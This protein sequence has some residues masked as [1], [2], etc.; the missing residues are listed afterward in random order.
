M[1]DAHPAG[2]ADAASY[3]GELHRLTR[4]AAATRGDGGSLSLDAAIEWAIR[5]IVSRNE[6]GNK[7]MVIGNGGSA[8]IA[9]HI[10]TDYT[11]NGGL[12]TQVFNDGSLLTCLGNDLGFERVFAKP[13]EM[14]ARRGD[15]LIAISSSGK[16]PNIH[17]GVEAARAAGC[18]VLTLSGFGADNPLRRMG[19]VN[20]YVASGEY[21]FV[22]LA[23]M[24]LCH[25]ILDMKMGWRP[26]SGA[27][28]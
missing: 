2:V 18:A 3:F 19:D 11:K 5:E 27:R 8:A 17:R 25:A 26:P 6:A 24:G 28:S 4:G 23:H 22:E 10:A 15:F 1:N 12:R 21:G 16:S 13:I 20:L 7:L 9:S 14:F